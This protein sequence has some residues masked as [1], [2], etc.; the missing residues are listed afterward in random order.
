MH[1]RFNCPLIVVSLL[2]V[3]RLVQNNTSTNSL[4]SSTIKCITSE[5]HIQY[6]ESMLIIQYRHLNSAPVNWTSQLKSTFSCKVIHAS[7]PGKLAVGRAVVYYVR[8]VLAS[9]A[10]IR[11]RH[12]YLS[13]RR[14]PLT[15]M[16]RSLR[17]CFAPKGSNIFQKISTSRK[18]CLEIIT[19]QST[20]SLTIQQ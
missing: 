4:R 13:V 5:N 3:L 15:D 1:T 12:C 8:P 16:G 6:I 17:Q 11:C 7:M 9:R 20:T 2:T 18:K 14:P 19:G 10:G